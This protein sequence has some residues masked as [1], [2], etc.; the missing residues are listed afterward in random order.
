M[1]GRGQWDKGRFYTY[2]QEGASFDGN[3][4]HFYIYPIKTAHF[5]GF[6]DQ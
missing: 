6:L 3:K 5:H 1:R 2:F 4:G